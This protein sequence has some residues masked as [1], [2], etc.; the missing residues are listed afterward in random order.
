MPRI[1]RSSLRGQFLL[2]FA[3]MLLAVSALG[4]CGL[5]S[6]ARM[7]E[8]GTAIRNGTLVSLRDS[9]RL[10]RALERF[11]TLEAHA[12]TLPAGGDRDALAMEIAR[13]LN[14]VGAAR[15]AFEPDIDPGEERAH[16]AD[17]DARWQAYLPLHD[18]LLRLAATDR[19]AAS[20]LLVGETSRRFH[21]IRD[22]LVWD[23]DYTDA[24]GAAQAGRGAEIARS[25][26]ELMLLGMAGAVLAAIG[27]GALLMHG[28]FG[29]LVAITA[30][31][32]RLAENDLSATIPG[33]GRDDEIG[34]IADAV[35][36]FRDGL[37][38]AE[39]LAAEQMREQAHKQRQSARVSEL[40]QGFERQVSGMTGTLA[41]AATQLEAT[42]DTMSRIATQ[43]THQ[44][45]NVA[46]AAEEAGTG[47]QTVAAAAEELAASVQEISRQVASS[48]RTTLEA[49]AEARRTDAVVRTLADGAQRIGQV[50]ELITGIAGQTNLLALNAT[51]EAAR[52]GDAGKGFAVVASEVKSLAQQTAKATEE[53]AAQ[54]SQIQ[55]ATTDAVT[56][57]QGIARRIEEVSAISTS[58][59]SA[60]AQQ[61]AATAEIA[62]NVAQTAGSAQDVTA[63]ISGV[64]Q[65]AGETGTAAGGVL[66]A[67]GALSRQAEQLTAEV[68]SFVAAIQAA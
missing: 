14:E 17:L 4:A 36:V 29:P 58:I 24:H 6:M 62:S 45:S 61:G 68:N 28:I 35:A 54:I 3:L 8:A 44:A 21:D 5:Y 50:V 48:A 30:T 26:R 53:I 20:A 46:A 56:A 67:A 33:L 51:I 37:V 55:A 34:A 49:V 22:L 12:V 47:V 31:M 63:N 10:S 7:E 27:V 57:I 65:A 25:A 9:I 19:D 66:Q 43:A 32:R 64:S 13:S 11:R 23:S 15:A 52:A 40:V 60:V 42:A 1:S 16:V 39:R 38:R 41:A 59:A 18:T 2:G